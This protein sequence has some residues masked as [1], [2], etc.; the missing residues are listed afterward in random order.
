[1][2]ENKRNTVRCAPAEKMYLGRLI[3]F[4]T[5]FSTPQLK[6]QF[7]SFQMHMSPFP[8]TIHNFDLFVKTYG[9]C[10]HKYLVTLKLQIR[11]SQLWRPLFLSLKR[12]KVVTVYA[13]DNRCNIW[14]SCSFN[15]LLTAI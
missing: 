4:C 9:Y 14:K 5:V 11:N 3:I 8:H 7:Q 1:M 10:S 15:F 12:V 13:F 2:S 6:V